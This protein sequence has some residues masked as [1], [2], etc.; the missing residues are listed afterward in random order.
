MKRSG[1]YEKSKILKTPKYFGKTN[2]TEMG[3]YGLVGAHVKTGWSHMAQD[4]LKTPPGPQRGYR[5]PNKSKKKNL[6]PCQTSQVVK[7]ATWWAEKSQGDQYAKTFVCL[8]Q[9]T[10]TVAAR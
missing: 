10:V 5:R 2:W 7:I 9:V 8:R 4:H 3:P 6:N 1:T